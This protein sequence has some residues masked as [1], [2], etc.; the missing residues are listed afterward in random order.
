[1]AG[2]S[3]GRAFTPEI[4][5]FLKELKAHNDREWFQAN[6]ARFQRVAQ[7]PM[8]AFIKDLGEQ[9]RLISPR[10]VAD[11]RPSGG[12][13]FRIYRDTRFS[14]N[15]A[16]Y[17]TWVAARFQHRAAAN[18]TSVPG[19]YLRLSPD[20]ST[21]GGGIYHPETPA[22]TAVRTRIVEKPREWRRVR[23]A[24]PDV[25]G[26]SLK[27]APAGFDADHP[28]VDDLK[29]KDF[30]VMQRFTQRQVTAPDFLDRYVAACRDA[31]P[32]VQFLTRALRLPW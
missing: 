10:F 16:P 20:G 22:L 25:Q 18:G 9:L 27:R 12:S 30:Y 21:G 4:F 8:L 13:M 24:V 14:A 23:K 28:L 29:L 31:S 7:A 17:K 26:S 3:S 32:L 2:A 15:K 6:K 1:M 5:R 19:F 11:P